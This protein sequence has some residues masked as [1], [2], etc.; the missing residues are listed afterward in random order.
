[1]DSQAGGDET[2]KTCLTVK[3][4][5]KILF[6]KEKGCMPHVQI[7]FSNQFATV[8]FALFIP[9]LMQNPM[10]VYLNQKKALKTGN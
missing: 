6:M 1:M 9:W 5:I 8:P 2:K 7:Y 10:T 4:L 3:L